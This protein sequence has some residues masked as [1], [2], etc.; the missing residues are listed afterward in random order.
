[1]K[2]SDTLSK[3]KTSV[4]SIAL[5]Y[6]LFTALGLTSFFLFMYVIG[7]SD[8]IELRSLN[9]FILITMLWLAIKAYMKDHPG[10]VYMQTLGLGVMTTAIGVIPFAIFIFIYLQVDTEFMTYIVENEMF[11]QYLNPY[12]LG[13]LI[14]FEGCLSGFFISFALMQYLKRKNV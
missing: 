12:I 8:I 11:G 10:N 1:M 7:L 6:G 13:F 3:D 4:E 2:T 9:F 5:K 14:A